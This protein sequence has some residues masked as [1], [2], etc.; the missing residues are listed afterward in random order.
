MRRPRTS[1]AP[2]RSP[3]SSGSWR[4]RSSV[5]PRGAA[6]PTRRR[7]GPVRRGRGPVRRSQGTR[8][9]TMIRRN[10]TWKAIG[11]LVGGGTY[12]VFTLVLARL[13]GPEGYGQ[14]AFAIGWS[15]LFVIVPEFG[16]NQILSRDLARRPDEGRAY[17]AR[18]LLVKAVLAALAAVLLV[19]ATAAHPAARHLA[20]LIGT[21]FV[22]LLV[23]SFGETGQ[24][25]AAAYE[26]FRVGAGLNILMKG[27]VAA[28]GFAAAVVGMGPSGV[29]RAVAVAGAAGLSA[30]AAYWGRFLRTRAAPS[31][32]TAVTLARAASPIFFQTVFISIYTRIGTVLLGSLKGDAET[33]LYSAAYRFVEVSHALPAAVVSVVTARLARAAGDE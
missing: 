18:A 15:G 20:P 33:G 2:R 29:M 8:D 28:C 26:R 11:T 23:L 14:Y 3:P 25:L 30:T 16:L 5:S 27:L 9:G 10:L 17:T 22:F 4:R 13:L 19:A 1:S 7:R 31:A 32:E 12:F 24:A 21:A 6:N